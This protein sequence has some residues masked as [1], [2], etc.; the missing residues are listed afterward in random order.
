[1][2]RIIIVF[3][4]IVGI[5]FTAF[6]AEPRCDQPDNWAALS[7]F[8]KLKNEGIVGPLDIDLA[9]TSVEHL[10]STRLGK[11]LWRQVHHITYKSSSGV[12]LLEIIAVNEATDEECSGSGV[13][14]FLITKHLPA[15]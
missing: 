14:I 8:A 9:K 10:G 1:M 15:Q 13:D 4:A 6:A 3:A 12:A 11:N 5:P 2:Y 7:S